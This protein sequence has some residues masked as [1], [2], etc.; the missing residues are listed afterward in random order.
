MSAVGRLSLPPTA[1][2]W[3]VGDEPVRIVALGCSRGIVN[4]LVKEGHG[5][6]AIDPDLQR[7]RQL[8]AGRPASEAL[9]AMVGRADELPVQPCVAHVVLLGGPWRSQPGRPRISAHQAH[10]QISRALQAGGWV[11]GWQIVRD[12]TVPWVRRLITLMRTIDPDA[13]SGS[14][15]GGHEDLLTSKYFPRIER[16]E[17]RLWAPVA[18]RDLVE[19]VSSQRQVSG[20]DDATKRH[21]I[22]EVNQILDSAARMSELRLP[23]QMQC[24]RAHVDHHELTQPISFGD[25]S[26]VIPI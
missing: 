13:M 4:R 10:G 6:V 14:G 19:M 18:R 22:S 12:D 11:A 21:L 26:L 20:L 2:Q 25:G 9:I 15:G 5:V 8:L 3:L 23:Y 24:W 16:R 7:C 1:L 17:F